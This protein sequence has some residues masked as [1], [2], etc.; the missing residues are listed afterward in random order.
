[1]HLGPVAA[2][3]S[4][5]HILYCVLGLIIASTLKYWIH[6]AAVSICCRCW[7]WC[8]CCCCRRRRC[9]CCF[10]YILDEPYNYWTW[11]FAVI[12]GSSRPFCMNLC[13]LLEC[14]HSLNIKWLCV[15]RKRSICFS[16]LSFIGMIFYPYKIAEAYT[17]HSNWS[18]KKVQ[19]IKY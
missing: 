14:M 3:L 19:K 17:E 9:C 1:M 11:V 5:I 6:K 18:I 13:L 8:W 2:A 7:C 12:L 16:Q 15:D 10:F 4:T